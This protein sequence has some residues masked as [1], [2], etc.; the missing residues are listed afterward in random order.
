MKVE[1]APRSPTVPPP[2]PA[3]MASVLERNIAAM[4]TRRAQVEARA[5]LQARAADGVSRFA[6]GMPFAYL[7]IVIVAAWVACNAGW[8]P[9][10]PRFDP[11][12]V[13]LATVASVEGIFL[14]TFVL[15]SQNRAAEAADRR[16]ELDLQINLLAEHEVTRLIS[17]TS[18]IAAKLGVEAQ[19]DAQLD[20]LKHDVAPEAVLDELD[21]EGADGPSAA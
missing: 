18:A 10:A 11:S 3:G 5:G 2:Q 13:I 4:K 6:G 17:L 7:H 14:T 21:R 1:P 8:W 12:F 15:I 9:G 20:E 16:A 19:V